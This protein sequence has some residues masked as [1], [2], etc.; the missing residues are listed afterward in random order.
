MPRST[1]TFSFTPFT[2]LSVFV[3]PGHQSVLVVED[4]FISVSLTPHGRCLLPFPP[5]FWSEVGL[6]GIIFFIPSYLGFGFGH[7]QFR[8]VSLHTTRIP[9]NQSINQLAPLGFI[10]WRSTDRKKCICISHGIE[11]HTV[12]I[13]K[14]PGIP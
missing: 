3:I 7:F 8:S 1:W 9:I 14:Y 6:G 12:C 2:L 4:I 13:S 5:S 10:V 11:N